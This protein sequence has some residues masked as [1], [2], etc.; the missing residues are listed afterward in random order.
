MGDMVFCSEIDVGDQELKALNAQNTVPNLQPPTSNRY[1]ASVVLA[2]RAPLSVL[3]LLPGLPVGLHPLAL[4]NCCARFCLVSVVFHDRPWK[5]NERV[6]PL[7]EGMTD[8]QRFLF[9]L[10]GFLFLDGALLPE[11]LAA[12]QARTAHVFYRPILPR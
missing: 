2:S 5:W 10:N 4:I 3:L 12:G 9:D 6:A 7:V 1:D 8:Q 11:E